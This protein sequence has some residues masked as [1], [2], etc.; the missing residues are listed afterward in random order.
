MYRPHVPTL[1]A[2]IATRCQHWECPKLKKFEQVSTDGHQMSLAE[3]GGLCSVTSH[4]QGGW[5]SL[6]S[7][8]LCSRE[9]AG[10]WLALYR[11]VQC[12]IGDGHMDPYPC[13]QNDGQIWLKTL[14]FRNFVGG[15]QVLVLMLIFASL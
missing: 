13:R 8:I 12:I 2:S 11:E 9:E 6:C 4:V 1:H 15:W 3:G 10:Q 5:G 14:P 7:E